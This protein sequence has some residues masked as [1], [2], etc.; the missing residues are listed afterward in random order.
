VIKLGKGRKPLMKGGKVVTNC[1]CCPSGTCPTS[2][3]LTVAFSGISLNCGC[4]NLS[5]VFSEWLTITTDLWNGTH[6]VPLF[7]SGANFSS[8]LLDFPNTNHYFVSSHADCSSPFV[9]ANQDAHI[10]LDCYADDSFGVPAGIYISA[11]AKA[12]YCPVFY[13]G[14]LALGTT[15]SAISNVAACGVEIVDAYLVDA[16]GVGHGGTVSV[17]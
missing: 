12:P 11:L 2:G 17:T 9:E 1:N 10:S 4:V 5:P 16:M 14:K 7:N 6:T 8:Y 3:S 15:L 13:S